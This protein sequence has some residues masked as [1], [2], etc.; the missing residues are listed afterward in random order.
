VLPTN[1]PPCATTT[2]FVC[3]YVF[4]WIGRRFAS[5]DY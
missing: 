1:A 2:A 4:I 5:Q 3:F